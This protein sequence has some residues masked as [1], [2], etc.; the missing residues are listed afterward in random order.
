M[1]LNALEKKDFNSMKEELISKKALLKEVVTRSKKQTT[2]LKAS[3]DKV[4]ALTKTA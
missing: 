1:G 4:V 3:E 2:A